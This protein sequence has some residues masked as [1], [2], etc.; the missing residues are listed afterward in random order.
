MTTLS[1][2]GTDSSSSGGKHED[3]LVKYLTGVSILTLALVLSGF[4]GLVQDW[5]YTKHGRPSLKADQEGSPPTWQESMFYLHFLSMPLFVFVRKDLVEQFASIQD[6]WTTYAIQ[7][8]QSAQQVSI[9][10][11]SAT[12]QLFMNTV[13]Q[14]VCVAG[15]HR[16]TTRVSALTVTLILVVRKA[17][18]LILSVVF[19]SNG[20]KDVNA[21][22]LWCGAALVLLGTVGYSM[23]TKGKSTADKEAQGKEAEK[24]RQ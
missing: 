12:M 5:T 21:T 19:L 7:K 14:L 6:S 24:K 2:S 9:T 10:V 16:L 1:A 18:S 23:G 22:L 20:S 13:T 8:F 17:V 4:L 11:P 15:V 3:D